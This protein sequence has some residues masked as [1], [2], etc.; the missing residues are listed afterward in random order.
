MCEHDRSYRS[1]EPST[2]D[3]VEVAAR[4]D[5]RTRTSSSDSGATH[6]AAGLQK[7]RD[8]EVEVADKFPEKYKDGMRC[9]DCSNPTGPG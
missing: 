1:S 9:R 6:R 3:D 4:Y 2:N 8:G 7:F 5:F